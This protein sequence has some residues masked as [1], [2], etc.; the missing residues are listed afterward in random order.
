M[1]CLFSILTI[2]LILITFTTSFSVEAKKKKYEG[3][4]EFVDEEEKLSHQKPLDRKNGY[5][6]PQV[7]F[8]DL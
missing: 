2:F 8:V 5:M 1:K 4:F 3:D 6:I 7:I